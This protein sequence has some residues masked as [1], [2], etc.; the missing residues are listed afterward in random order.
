M[1][2]GLDSSSVA[3]VAHQLIAAGETEAPEFHT[4]SFVYERSRTSDERTFIRA[5]EEKLGRPGL[6]VGEE[7]MTLAQLDAPCSETPT[8]HLCFRQYDRVGEL[9]RERGARVLLT[10]YSG[11][12][13][14][15]SQVDA[16]L[17][18]ADLL[19]QRRSGRGA[20]AQRQ[21]GGPRAA[22]PLGLAARVSRGILK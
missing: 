9:M 11:D 7:S 22:S 10:G 1:S 19:Q 3:C 6:H 2:G 12:S 21:D 20:S 17:E 4:V 16:P 15:W 18:L 13:A 14:L 5:V 8:T